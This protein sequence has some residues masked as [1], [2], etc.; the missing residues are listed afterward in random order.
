MLT[1]RTGQG[2][3]GQWRWQAYRVETTQRSD[4]GEDVETV[5]HRAGS[6]VRGFDTEDD[7]IGDALAFLHDIQAGKVMLY[8]SFGIPMPL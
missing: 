8:N 2:E 3:A 6:T 7:A 4:T 1:F 5:S